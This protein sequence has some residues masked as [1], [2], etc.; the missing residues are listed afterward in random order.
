MDDHGT[1]IRDINGHSAWGLS[2]V[3][4]AI[5]WKDLHRIDPAA[6]SKVNGGS[7]SLPCLIT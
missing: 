3:F 1:I 2:R 7:C 6:K 4:H 5:F